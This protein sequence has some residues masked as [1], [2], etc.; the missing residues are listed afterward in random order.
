MSGPLVTQ[1][2]YVARLGSSREPH[3]GAGDT[4][5]WLETGVDGEIS[6]TVAGPRRFSDNLVLL[7]IVQ[8]NSAV[9]C[10]AIDTHSLA[11]SPGNIADNHRLA[12]N[13][14]RIVPSFQSKRHRGRKERDRDTFWGRTAPRLKVLMAGRVHWSRGSGTPHDGVR[15]CVCACEEPGHRG[16]PMTGLSNTAIAAFSGYPSSGAHQHR[17]HSRMAGRDLVEKSSRLS[18]TRKF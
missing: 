14:L 1:P 11:P 8:W 18:G 3:D 9:Y 4:G 2:S 10:L 5:V 13:S 16:L 17:E 12:V 15:V 7:L 6:L